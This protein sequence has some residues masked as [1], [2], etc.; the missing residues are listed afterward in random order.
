MGRIRSLLFVPADSEKEIAKALTAAADALIFDRED[1]VA[2]ERGSGRHECCGK[3]PGAGAQGRHQVAR[4][5]RRIE[6]QPASLRSSPPPIQVGGLTPIH[7][8]ISE[9]CAPARIATID[10]VYKRETRGHC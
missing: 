1:S 8:A 7:L 3:D 6:A 2:P 10:E 5:A 9:P 4:V